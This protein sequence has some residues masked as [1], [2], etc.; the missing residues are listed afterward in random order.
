MDNKIRAGPNRKVNETAI[1]FNVTLSSLFLSA[2]SIASSRYSSSNDFLMGLLLNGRPYEL[3]GSQGMV[4]M[5]M[6]TLPYR[7]RI[8][9]TERLSS[10]IQSVHK[11]QLEIIQNQYI[12]I[13]QIRSFCELGTRQN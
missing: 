6:N 13:N 5:F 3:D 11:D 4:G 7:A 10:F 12:S 2:I 1:E 9:E 8:D